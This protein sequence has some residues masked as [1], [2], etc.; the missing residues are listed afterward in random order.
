M[1]LFRNPQLWLSLAKEIWERNRG[2]NLNQ[3]AG[4]LAF[5]T[6]LSLVPMVT[7][8]TI[9]ISYLPK[10]IQIKNA[11]KNW[12]LETYMPGGLNE[13][14]FIY[15]D[16]FSAQA[17]GLT[18]LGLISLFITAIMTLSVIE[19]AFNQ[20]FKVKLRRPLHKKV[21]IY[22]TATILG[23]ILLGLGVYLSGILFSAAEGW[24]DSVSAGFKLIATI[25]PI[26]LAII[27]YTVVYKV[28]PY[29]QI[30]LSD[31]FSGGFFAALSFEAMKF[32]FA[33]FLTHTAFYKT[34]YGAFA[35]L[36]LA[37][38]WI[39]LTWWITLAGAVLVANLPSIRSGVIRVIRY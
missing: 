31:A 2:Q 29:A 11:F 30:S 8:A 16:Q 36:P 4:G 1:R 22:A 10:V 7:I 21:A 39:Y 18:L 24:T 14:V 34:V 3:I 17:R 23:P 38:L 27:V 25:A 19:S 33:I 32:G 26:I 37:L 15:L 13:Q 28:L 6:T 35:I 5:T 9:L 20:I 12:L